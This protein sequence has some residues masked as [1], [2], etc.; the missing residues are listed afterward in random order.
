MEKQLIFHILGIDET[1]DEAVIKSAYLNLL[2]TTNPED[3]PDGFKRLREAYESAVA[4]ARHPK[5]EETQ[6][7]SETDL[8]IDRVD[9]LYRDI[10]TR[11]DPKAWKEILS[12][13]LCED[14]DT[15]LQAREALLVYLMDHIYLPHAIWQI[16]DDTFQIAADQENLLNQFSK[17]YLDYVL[18]YIENEEFIDYNLF[19]VTN[20]EQYDADGYI[21]NY[22][23]LKRQIDQGQANDGNARSEWVKHYE[24]LQAFGI[25]HP[26]QDCEYLRVCGIALEDTSTGEDRRQEI[27]DDILRILDNLQTYCEESH[28][29]GYYYGD[30]CWRLGRKKE[31]RR[32]WEKIL[33][34]Y[35]THF[36][37][38]YSLIQYLMEQG[39][40][41]QAKEYILDLLDVDSNDESLLESMHT[42]NEA[43]IREYRTLIG[44]PA[45]AS[46]R[47]ENTMELAW[48]LFQ[49]EQ[50]DEVISLLESFTPDA[51]QEYSYENL[52]GR[53]LYRAE[54][55]ADA[56]PHLVRWLDLIRQT[57]DDGSAEM[58]KR[59]SRRFRAC[60][61]L[62][63]CCYELDR[64]EESLD[65]VEQ[66][67]HC[68]E[69]TSDRLAG[70][71]YK[72]FLLFQ[73]GKYELCIDACDQ[74]VEL[75][76]GYFPAYLQ[77]QEAAFKLHRG[78]QVV[79][80]YYQATGIYA[81]YY[82]PYLLAAQ[83]FFY[84]NQFEDAK[85]V[86]DRAHENG[87]E[88]T[89]C[90]RLYEVK[91]LRNLTENKAERDEA[92]K[93]AEDLLRLTEEHLA[94][95]SEDAEAEEQKKPELPVEAAGFDIDDPSEAEFE[96]GLL[97]WDS[98][99]L[100]EA[101]KHLTR[102]VEQNPDRLQYRLIRG[103]I[104]LDNQN[105]KRA[106]EDYAAAEEAYSDAPSLHYN[107]ADCYENLHMMELARESLEKT[108]ELDGT[109]RDAC[110]KLSNY[111]KDLYTTRC[112]P[113]DFKKAEEYL[114]RQLAIRENCYYLVE[115]GR[116]YMASF[117]LDLAIA[118]F[119]KAL[120]YEPRDWAACNNLGCCYKY[121]GDF[122]QAI[123][124]LQKAVDFLGDEKN[125][126]P[127][128]NMADCYEALGDY[129]SAIGC[130]EKD[131]KMFPRQMFLY[132]ELGQLYSYLGEYETALNYFKKA[133]D[134]E[135]YCENVALVYFL[136]DGGKRK[137]IRHY[138]KTIS[139]V[140]DKNAK[141][142]L[143]YALGS[144][145]C[146]YLNDL[147]RA[148]SCYK[149]G[150]LLS[151]QESKLLDL[152]WR[153]SICLFR[154]GK[155]G[156]A[157]LHARKAMEHFA[158][159]DC[160][161]EELYLG[162]RQYRASRLSRMGWLYICLGDAD[163]GLRLL[164]EMNAC[165]RCRMCRHP[166][167]FECYLFQGWYYEAIGNYPEALKLYR[168]AEQLNPHEKDISLAAARMEK[169]VR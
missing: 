146:D 104:Y 37:A 97:H 111:Y 88:F 150:A 108:L 51:E 157:Q 81:G 144:F 114:N 126:L 103:H 7:K 63:G 19:T 61:I 152:E 162:Y 5:Q 46:E 125:V 17:N 102:A 158:K 32:I 41:R 67:I 100:D 45:H 84:H 161:S 18:Y 30:A 80:D 34:Q 82:K 23:E 28:Y 3:D 13:P 137:A 16:I 20:R 35:P 89:P 120:T 47:M 129:R 166:E 77:R 121:L 29:V 131:L 124:Y 52:Y 139:T 6:E 38:K 112:D 79:D 159:T 72:A 78:Q 134:R 48:C 122:R 165:T 36:M 11:S 153:M 74:A 130:Y 15:S 160:P 119:K 68:A 142:N 141:A 59:I 24:E 90:L 54:R 65:Y 66:A 10:L 43:L 76:D 2:K 118:D 85:G 75:D 101:L 14:L 167:C 86:I 62:S 4:L 106:L 133:P 145:Y 12:D 87:V 50:L 107:R 27:C 1:A 123:E 64:Q 69:N 92:L 83:V 105:Y 117:D 148:V 55:Y 53:V 113:A 115:R 132:E 9:R 138:E 109:F 116:L 98:N 140:T 40:F 110:W 147:P 73:Y 21:R 135:D 42:A 49:N 156:D 169:K 60:H 127:Y 94:E 26:F 22:L 96:V 155:R 25:Y 56:L 151:D 39:D 58:K 149:R 57:V 70:T 95:Q 99:H 154:M 31:A 91:I 8:W 71:Q 33:E 143:Y 163:K 136:S 128:S 44:D 93:L 168:R 164:Q